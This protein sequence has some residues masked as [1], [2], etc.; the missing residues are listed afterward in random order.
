MADLSTLS[1]SSPKETKAIASGFA[2]GSTVVID[3]KTYQKANQAILV[4]DVNLDNVMFGDIMEEDIPQKETT[5]APKGRGKKQQ[6]LKYF[7]IPMFY[8]T[9]DDTVSDFLV[10]LDEMF[11]F[12]V[13][14]NEDQATGEL[15]GHSMSF[16][17]YSDMKEKKPHEIR[18]QKLHDDLKLRCYEHMA[19]VADK[20]GRGDRWTSA[21]SF[22]EDN[23]KPFYWTKAG[24]K[25]EKSPA[26]YA[27]IME[28]LKDGRVFTSFY[29][30]KD[31]PIENPLSNVKYCN[32]VPVVKYET[33]YY[34]GGKISPQIKL[35]EVAVK[36]LERQRTRLLK[37]KR[38]ITSD[39][40]QDNN[41]NSPPRVIKSD[42]EKPDPSSPQDKQ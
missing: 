7:K 26:L 38:N 32:A 29:D 11:S 31:E 20:L 27:K 42:D 18:M 24:Q 6:Q 14:E 40:S 3:G 28:S 4:E 30:E 34:G 12:G 9:G 2:K 21:A 10:Q 41:N 1:I 35:W 8:K 15:N 33:L 22:N 36:R 39:S 5:T 25:D 13:S 37:P 23:F 17:F 19:K 16:V